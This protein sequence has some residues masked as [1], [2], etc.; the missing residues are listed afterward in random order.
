MTFMAAEIYACGRVEIRVARSA[1]VAERILWRAF[2]NVLPIVKI[3]L[4][5]AF[6]RVGGR[7]R[8][9]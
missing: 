3:L 7:R 8:P 2:E 1:H 9:W 5:V 4:G 6:I